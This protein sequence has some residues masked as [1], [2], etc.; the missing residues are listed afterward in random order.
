[1]DWSMREAEIMIE[2]QKMNVENGR[3]MSLRHL[4]LLDQLGTNLFFRQPE[5]SLLVKLCMTINYAE[6]L[7]VCIRANP[8]CITEYFVHPPPASI[9]KLAFSIIHNFPQTLP[10]VSSEQVSSSAFIVTSKK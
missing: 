5:Y 8:D 2:M 9:M 1:M 3:I 7:F 6:F 4:G 10:Y